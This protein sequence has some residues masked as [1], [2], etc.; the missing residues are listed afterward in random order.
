M[1]SERKQAARVDLFA[2]EI[3][4][5]FCATIQGDYVFNFVDLQT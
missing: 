1:D 2:G 3:D 4:K 5:N